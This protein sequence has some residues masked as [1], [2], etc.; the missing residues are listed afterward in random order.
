M[1]VLYNA[2]FLSDSH[3][4]TH[5]K[6]ILE[7]KD[8]KLFKLLKNGK[9]KYKKIIHIGDIVCFDDFSA[10][11]PIPGQQPDTCRT[12]ELVEEFYTNL[13]KAAPTAEI[14]QVEGNHE[15]RLERY[16][17][18]NAPHL[19]PLGC[20][21]LPKLFQL[22]KH[23]INWKAYRDRLTLDGLKVTHGSLIRPESGN[24]ARAELK[25]A[26]F[27]TGIS[28][29]THRQGFIKDVNVSWL[30]LGNLCDPD[31]GVS[32]KYMADRDPNWNPGFGEGTCCVDDYGKLHWFLKPIEIIDNY[33]VVDG[34]V[35]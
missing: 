5:N 10:H 2:L 32:A 18:R 1:K 11:D 4:P 22:E 6:V 7:G 24:S 13:R 15:L 14:W 12:F 27:Q 35:Y 25:A 3:F 20:L 29:H 23:K 30:E 9:R 28:G 17:V 31:Y 33:F 8:A 21:S 16:L 19:L 26:K 34:V